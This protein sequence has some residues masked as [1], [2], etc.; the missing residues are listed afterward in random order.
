MEDMLKFKVDFVII[1]TKGLF[2]EIE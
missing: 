2:Y 1:Y